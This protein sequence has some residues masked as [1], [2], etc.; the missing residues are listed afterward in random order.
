MRR[1]LS[2]YSGLLVL[3]VHQLHTE[4]LLAVRTYRRLTAA[5]SSRQW[6]RI[7]T[8][9]S[10]FLSFVYMCCS[11]RARSCWEVP[12][13]RVGS[14]A[15]AVAARTSFRVPLDLSMDSHATSSESQHACP[16]WTNQCSTRAESLPGFVDIRQGHKTTLD[17]LIC[18]RDSSMLP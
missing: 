12:S 4:K 14:N 15:L 17:S 9:P 13:Y 10:V 2:I 6:V 5:P 16:V 11:C 1:E 7:I 3:A 8:K 18:C